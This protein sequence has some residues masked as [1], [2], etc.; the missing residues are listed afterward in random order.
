[1]LEEK[2]RRDLDRVLGEPAAEVAQPCLE[3]L[4]RHLSAVTGIRV[5]VGSDPML[6][7]IRGAGHALDNLDVLKRNFMYIR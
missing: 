6:A 5:T 3:G 4:D 1:M 7:V 2:P